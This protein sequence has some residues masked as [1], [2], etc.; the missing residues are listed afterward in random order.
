MA[1]YRAVLRTPL[2]GRTFIAALVGR[3]SYGTV[4]LSLVLACTQAT[5]SYATAGGAIALFGLAGSLLSPVRARLIDRHGVRRALPPMAVAYAL[6]L[7][8]LAALTWRPGTP[9]SLLWLVAGLTGAFAPPL[10][11]I[12]RALWSDLLADGALLQRAYSVDTVAEELLYVA[13]PLIAGML[14]GLAHPSLGVA[15]SAGLVTVGSLAL[16]SSPAA[17]SDA[18]ERSRQAEGADVS[19]P[20]TGVRPE[21]GDI[22]SR[23]PPD[24]ACPFW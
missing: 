23:A 12:M 20:S 8:L 6:L 18:R 17:R 21:T 1:S 14:A 24:S 2:A 4:F 13:G 5:G 11:P 16:A 10:G 15:A 3:L 22:R 19:R 7:T 9:G